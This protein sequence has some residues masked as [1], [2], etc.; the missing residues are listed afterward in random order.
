MPQTFSDVV[1]AQEEIAG[2]IK[3]CI[4]N[5]DKLGAAKLSA[6]V[7][8]KRIELLESYWRNFT[9]NHNAM[10]PMPD[11][12]ASN[13]RKRGLYDEVEE[14]YIQNSSEL[15]ERL[16]NL[17]PVASAIPAEAESHECNAG[18][19]LPT[20]TIEKFSGDLL[21]WEEFRDSFR[22]TIHNSKRLQDVQRLQYL[23]ASLT[24]AAAKVIARTSLTDANYS[25]AWAALER[26]YGGIRVLTTA[27]LGRLL[28][29]PAVKRASTEELTRVLDEFCQAR[30][31]LAALKKPVDTW[32]DWFVTLLV[33]KLDSTTRLDWEKMFPDPTIM[34]SFVEIRDFLESR[35][36]ALAS[37]QEPMCSSTPTKREETRKPEQRT[38]MTVQMTKGPSAKA[39]NVRKCPLCS[40][41]HQLGHC[42]QFKTFSASERKEFVYRNKLCVSCFSGTHLLAACTSSYRCMV[43]GGHHHT[44]LHEAFRKSEAPAQ[45]STSSVNTFRSNRVVL[46]ATARVQ[47]KSPNGRS[48]SARALLDPGSEMSFVTDHVVQALRLPRRNVEVHLTGYQEIN[49][50]TVRHEVSVLLASSRDS[51]FRLA[52]NALVTRK[53]T[54]PTPAVEINDEKWTHLHGLPLADEDFRSPNRVELLLGADACGHLLL[55]NRIGPMGTPPIVRTPFGWAPMGTTS[56]TTDHS[57]GPRVRSLLVQP[58][59]DL[60]DDWQRF[61][62]LEEVP[63][64]AISTPQDEACEKYFKDTHRRDQDGRYVVR[65]PFVA[66]P[67]TDVG[68]PRSAAV[69]L[70][71]SSERRRERDETLRQK[72]SEF[73]EEYERLGH[74]EFV[75][76]HSTGGGENYLPHHAVWREKPS[77][78]KIR[79]VFNGSYVSGRGSAINDYL[80]AGPKLQTD[81]WAVI[82]RWRFHRHAFSTDIVKM[83]RQIK[84]HPED[85]DWQRIVWRK[86]PSEEVRD[87]RLTTVTYGTTSAPYLASRVLLQ[88]ADDE[89][90]RFPRGA[91]ILRAN[92]YVDDILAGGDD[93]DDTEE[94]RR[95]LTD[96]LT[97]GG[98]PLDKWATNYLSSSSGL[99]QLL[100]GHQEA[101]ALGLKWSTANDT[102]SLAAPKL[103][104]A[105]S[106]QPWTKRSVLSETARLFDPL[107][108]L[109][110]ISIAAKILLQDLWLSGLLWDEPLS[111]LFSERWKQLRFEMERTDRITVP[112]WIG[113]RAATSDN[114]ELHGFSDASE[115][116]YSAAVFIRVPVTGARAETHLLMA[117]TKVAPTKPQSIPRLEL[118]GALL[119][120]RLLRAVGDSMRPHSVT[121]HAWTD[122][123]VVLAWV[124]SHASRW[125]PVTVTTTMARKTKSGDHPSLRAVFESPWD[126]LRFSSALRLVRVTAYM[127]R[128]A[129]NARS[130]G[131]PQHGFLTATEIDEAWVSVHRMSQADDFGDELAEMEKDRQ[132]VLRVGGRLDHAAVSFDQRHP[133]IVDRQSPLA[134]LLIRSA[135]LRTLHGGVNLTRATL[136]LRHW[137][138]R[139]KT[140]VKRVVKGCVTCTRLQGRTSNQQMG[141]LPAQ[142]VQPA[143]AFSVSGVDYAGPIPMLMTRARG[144]RTT[145]GY[146]VVF[147]CL[148][149]KAVHLDVVSDL[150]SASFIAAFKRFVARRGRCHQMLSDNATTFRG[151]DQLLKRMFNAASTFYKETAELLAADGTEWRFIPPYSPHF[152]GLW[153]A[154]VKSAK[155]HLRRTIGEQQLTFEEL[156]TLL[157]QV[158]AF[159][160][161]GDE[162]TYDAGRRRWNLVSRLLEGF[163]QRWRTEYLSQL[164]TLPKWQRARENLAVGAVVLLKDDLA[165]PPKWP[166]GRV[167]EVHRGSDGRVRVA[168][169]KTATRTTTRAIQRLV[170]L[171]SSEHSTG[172]ET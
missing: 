44:S 20:L 30:D 119:L 141:M 34:P 28:D 142:R 10:R 113:Y 91:A 37:T 78:N 167:V 108:W 31:A 41:N 75:S 165:P 29:C 144:Q 33:R 71:L 69:R 162:I 102:L 22:A 94:A 146:V 38:A 103:R 126:P 59:R 40:D 56:S 152:G 82:T 50:G 92:S 83:F 5:T 158:E 96:I 128:F 66:T 49:V 140:L 106:G 89:K 169:V 70:L 138:P 62:E 16:E 121:M 26:R 99:I 168:V 79:V 100:Q 12:A 48:V 124:R 110:P 2:R 73:L 131:T 122:A 68:V 72:Y 109:S 35:I 98:F 105:T 43:C 7:L 51:K 166:L 95:Q 132:G 84:V 123:S 85:R 117:K 47:L 160:E 107:G 97:A 153:E 1:V 148:C 157:C 143:R 18:P 64:S 136:R 172:E 147:V 36:H 115:R 46:L 67:G 130:I 154:A 112:R 116:A 171:I 58:A 135:H 74:M 151:A 145:K 127:R 125:K 170:P 23:K 19:R 139:D 42:G 87:F 88:L 21:R 55:E 159:P 93:I 114:I 80:A 63:T 163:W 81:L 15:V 24:G 150:S 90:A 133:V 27:H 45:P 101:G 9:A 57:A 61:W 14:A 137:I 13:Y 129:N 3:N 118:C 6:V 17:K 60:R 155:R 8:Q 120:A 32:D 25:T 156:S 54:A 86:D 77:G 104:T 76:R 39:S 134:P 111:E 164:Q 65:L 161:P 11:Y 53:I 4:I 52:L 149:T